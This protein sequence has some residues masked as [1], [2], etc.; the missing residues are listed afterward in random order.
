MTSRESNCSLQYLPIL[1]CGTM[2]TPVRHW[3]EVELERSRSAMEGVLKSLIPMTNAALARD[4]SRHYGYRE[5][6]PNV[7]YGSL[8]WRIPHMEACVEV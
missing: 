2:S 1:P 6:G 7:A 5:T 3:Y 8:G 4:Y